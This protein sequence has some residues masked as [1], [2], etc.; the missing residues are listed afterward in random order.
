MDAALRR[1]RS[2]VLAGLAL[3]AVLGWA[4]LVYLARAMAPMAMSPA[5]M[6]MDMAMP[7][8]QGWGAGDLLLTFLMWAVMMAA[9]MVPSVSP[10]VLVFT[11]M[12]RKR[13]ARWPVLAA[14]A[15]VGGYL[16]IWTAFSALA[17]LG[18][19]GLHSA[20]LLSPMMR[21]TSPLLGGALLL[22]AGIFQWTPLKNACLTHCRTP[23][24][25]LLSEW[26]DGARGAFR[27]GLSHGVYCV[28]C[29]WVLMVLLFAAGVMNL[30]WVA[31]IAA[32]VLLEKIVPGPWLRRAAGV[33]LAAGAVWMAVPFAIAGT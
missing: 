5:S 8:V 33:L 17:T 21:S 32:F 18:Q 1:D 24:G 13:A 7:R 30:F 28:G 6:P 27:M 2:L 23:M 16:V 20:A 31:V 11:G 14:A 4:Y 12:L 3:I 29:C 15:F 9:M 22:A 19:W 25:F 26:R 10:M